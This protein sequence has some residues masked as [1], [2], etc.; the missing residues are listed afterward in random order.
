MICFQVFLACLPFSWFI[1]AG[2]HIWDSV[3]S[4]GGLFGS[5]HRLV[6]RAFPLL[7]WLI[8]PPLTLGLIPARCSIFW[9]GVVRIDRAGESLVQ[10]N[11]EAEAKHSCVH[12]LLIHSNDEKNGM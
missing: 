8:A 4:L 10:V 6:K 1:P 3:F 5:D 9:L 11:D 12:G 2:D 7:S